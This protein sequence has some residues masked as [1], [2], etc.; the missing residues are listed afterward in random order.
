MPHDVSNKLSDEDLDKYHKIH[1]D[2]KEQNITSTYSFIKM[3]KSRCKQAY[4]GH[5]KN[6]IQTS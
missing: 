5:D 4:D 2:W 1:T 6:Q 3:S